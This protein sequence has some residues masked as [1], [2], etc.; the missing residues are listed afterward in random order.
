M[1]FSPYSFEFSNLYSTSSAVN[2]LSCSSFALAEK[3]TTSFFGLLVGY[4]FYSV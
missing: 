1:V 2:K 3:W 4:N